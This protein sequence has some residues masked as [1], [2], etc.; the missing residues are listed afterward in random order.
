LQRDD[1]WLLF[2]LTATS[3]PVWFKTFRTSPGAVSLEDV[4]V[5]QGD[6][7]TPEDFWR[8]AVTVEAEPFAYGP[9][10]TFTV[11]AA[12]DPA[13]AGG[14]G[15]TLPT[16]KGDAPAPLVLRVNNEGRNINH[17]IAAVGPRV[18]L[19]DATAPAGSTPVT[20]SA[21]QSGGTAYQ[22]SLGSVSG[23]EL[24]PFTNPPDGWN[25]RGHMFL[26]LRRVSGTAAVT[27]TRSTS[28]NSAAPVGTLA[29]SSGTTTP[30]LIDLGPVYF[31][32]TVDGYTQPKGWLMTLQGQAASGTVV[33][34]V[35]YL[36]YLPE[37]WS[38]AVTDSASYASGYVIDAEKEYTAQL[39]TDYP[40][41]P[42]VA[43]YTSIMGGLV[44]GFP[45]VRPGETNVL[46]WQTIAS[47]WNHPLGDTSTIYC[48]YRPRWLFLAAS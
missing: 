34:E 30:V 48:S 27:I 15:V 38:F 42:E 35:D 7:D 41:A 39:S 8:V 29:D 17:I 32:P 22:V 25:G 24:R 40:A 47:N 45:E 26:R 3:A 2:Q 12:N 18:A 21:V 31:T 46:W 9:Q 36:L 6:E 16:I 37:S 43:Y 19:T 10:E 1:N 5:P 28:L 11:T 13:V 44:G 20:G 33:V 14:L 23:V 4:W